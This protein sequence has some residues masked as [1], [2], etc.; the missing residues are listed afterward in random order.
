MESVT[1]IPV[2]YFRSIM[3]PGQK[4]VEVPLSGPRCLEEILEEA[5]FET[6]LVGLVRVNGERRLPR[7]LVEPGDEVKV[8]AIAAGG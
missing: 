3:P 1:I 6:E 7:T 5:G 4:Q 8:S 2:C